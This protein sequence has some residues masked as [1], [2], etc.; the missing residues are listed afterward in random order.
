MKTISRGDWAI[1]ILTCC[2][3]E[4]SETSAGSCILTL[5]WT[6]PKVVGVFR[7]RLTG[8]VLVRG[9]RSKWN[10]LQPGEG[11][12]E[13][14]RPRPAFR[15]MQGQPACRAGEPSGDREEPP[16]EGLGGHHLLTRTD[17]R[18]PA[19]QVCAITWTASQAALAAK[20]QGCG[21]GVPWASWRIPAW[22]DSHNDSWANQWWV[23]IEFTLTV[24]LH[25]RCPVQE[26]AG[27]LD[28]CPSR[29]ARIVVATGRTNCR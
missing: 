18:C 23:S 29:S 26:L 17:A 15:K 4:Q 11:A 12:A 8:K 16:P 2:R 25:K 19:G 14:L 5:I 10:R 28:D 6:D 22:A 1:D 20:R 3:F 27:G 13:L 24:Y 21:I 7:A 9:A